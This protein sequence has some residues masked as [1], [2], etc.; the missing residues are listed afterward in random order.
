M[1]IDEHINARLSASSN[2]IKYTD[3]IKKSFKAI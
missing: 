2:K 3:H 1:R